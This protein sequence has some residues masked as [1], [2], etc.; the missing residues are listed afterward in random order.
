MNNMKRGKKKVKVLKLS[1][2]QKTFYIFFFQT[3][4]IM[5]C[6]LE[7]KELFCGGVNKRSKLSHFPDV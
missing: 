2:I 7:I 4:F 6:N 3:Q 1:R 5:L